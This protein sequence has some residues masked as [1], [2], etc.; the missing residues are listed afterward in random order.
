M[1][2][3]KLLLLPILA[4]TATMHSAYIPTAGTLPLSDTQRAGTI[5]AT[6]KGNPGYFKQEQQIITEF[7]GLVVPFNQRTYQE[8]IYHITITEGDLALK[9]LEAYGN[10]IMHIYQERAYLIKA[11]C[12]PHCSPIRGIVYPF[13]NKAALDQLLN[14]YDQLASI[15]M[16]KSPAVGARMKLI[17]KS[18]KYWYWK[19][20]LALA[21]GAYGLC[22][23]AKKAPNMQSDWSNTISAPKILAE[24]TQQVKGADL[25]FLDHAF[26]QIL[27]HSV[28]LP[29]VKLPEL[30]M[31]EIK[32]PEVK[33]PELKVP[34]FFN[35]L[36]NRFSLQQKSDSQG[37]HVE[38]SV[39]AFFKKIAATYQ[40]FSH[41]QLA[42]YYRMH[43]LNFL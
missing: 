18:Y 11:R 1:K 10:V 3:I 12:L 13:A 40:N 16:E 35:T 4:L 15:A 5:T 2:I 41:E 23:M 32:L 43:G 30:K 26:D 28:K 7:A 39:G 20:T 9:A 6:L 17:V 33:L 8:M 19:T 34:D 38:E 29:E 22:V 37:F 21:A 27:D 31:P 36:G 42:E 25:D 24:P 14:E